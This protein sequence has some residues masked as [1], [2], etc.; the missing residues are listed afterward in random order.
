LR[1]TRRDFFKFFAGGAILLSIF[2]I[3]SIR[4]FNET[5]GINRPPGALEENYFNLYCIRCGICLEVCPTKCL[6]FAGFNEGIAS[7]NTPKIDAEAGPCEFYRGRCKEEMLCSKYCPTGALQIANRNKVKIGTVDFYSNYCL[8]HM[9]KECAV[10]G[11][12]CPVLGAIETTEDLKPIFNNEK[13]VGCGTC[14]YSCPANPKALSLS[15]K[16]SKRV[17]LKR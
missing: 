1:F 8:A 5:K 14:V 15:S 3:L 2:K 7:I 6:V 9:G 12:M 10:C 13:C 11:E 16:G 4:P 17:K